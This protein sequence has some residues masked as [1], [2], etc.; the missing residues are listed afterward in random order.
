MATHPPRSVA[1]TVPSSVRVF[2][3]R[4]GVAVAAALMVLAI[5]LTAQDRTDGNGERPEMNDPAA[6]AVPFG[7]GER[8]EYRVKLGRIDVGEGYLAVQG[9]DTVRGFPTYRLDL[10]I[11]ASALFGAA[12]LNDRYQSWLDTRT[13]VSR[14]FI[15][16]LDQTGYQGR[17]VFEIYPEEKRWERVDADKGEATPSVLPLDE[18]SFLYYVRT[19]PLK[20]GE[21]YNLNRYFKLDG[22]PVTVKVLRRE[23]VTVPAG[24]F[25]TVV[26][27]PVIRTSGLFSE[28]GEAEIYLTD[29]ENRHLVYLR[30]KIPVVGSLSLHLTRLREGIPLHPDA[31]SAGSGS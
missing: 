25:E 5:P 8:M 18:I 13:L 14:R 24:T 6:M 11:D 23:R 3:R 2:G 4:R 15:R 28:G 30:S 12:R 21:E 27:Q 1:R 29:D 7:P 19:L 20:V 31:R 16:D 10:K 17:R 22:N 9:V 26:L